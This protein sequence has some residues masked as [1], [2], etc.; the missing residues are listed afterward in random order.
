MEILIFIA[1]AQ[2]DSVE[3][4]AREEYSFLVSGIRGHNVVQEEHFEF[5]SISLVLNQYV[6]H[7][8]QSKLNDLQSLL[9]TT[10]VIINESVKEWELD[11]HIREI[12]H[13]SLNLLQAKVAQ[14]NNFLSTFTLTELNHDRCSNQV[15]QYC[16]TSELQCLILLFIHSSFH[17]SSSEPFNQ[18]G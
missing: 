8:Q 15:E 2:N 13:K 4:L 16:C 5:M 10:L 14:I 11:S 18:D 1:T 7:I 3:Y 12:L 6:A 9:I 17:Y